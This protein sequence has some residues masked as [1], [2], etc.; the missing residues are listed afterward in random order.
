MRTAYPKLPGVAVST[1]VSDDGAAMADFASATPFEPEKSDFLHDR[2]ELPAAPRTAPWITLRRLEFGILSVLLTI[3]FVALEF[4]TAAGWDGRRE[5]E[6]P[7]TIPFAAIAA[8]CLASMLLR[9]RWLEAMP[10][11][12]LLVLALVLTGCNIWRAQ[13]VDG[14][15]ALRDALTIL[16]A[17]LMG[18]ATL[19][20]VAGFFWAEWRHPVKAPAPEV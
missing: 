10:G 17:V 2:K 15:D 16:T 18:F 12:G 6:V 4:Q 5:F 13:Y 11:L 1:F 9:G 14:T 19:A 8:V 3:G 7:V 20:F